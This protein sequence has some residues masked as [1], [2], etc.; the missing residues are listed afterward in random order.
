MKVS[1]DEVL[2]HRG[3]IESRAR[4]LSSDEHEAEDLTQ[5]TLLYALERPPKSSFALR[6]WLRLVV[7]HLAINS[8]VSRRRQL[9]REHRVAR[10]SDL[11]EVSHAPSMEQS[12]EVIRCV[13][14]LHEPYRTVITQHYLEGHNTSQIAS[15]LGIPVGT[16]KSR[17]RKGRELLL[18][19]YSRPSSPRTQRRFGVG[20]LLGLWPTEG[21]R[22]SIWGWS[23]RGLLVVSASLAVLLSI[24]DGWAS[25]TPVSGVAA[26]EASRASDSRANQVITREVGVFGSATEHRRPASVDG[27]GVRGTQVAAEKALGASFLV[28]GKHG[29]AIAFVDIQFVPEDANSTSARQGAGAIFSSSLDGWGSLDAALGPGLL[30]SA[31]PEWITVREGVVDP[32]N[33]HE[34]PVVMVAPAK[35]I[36]GRVVDPQGNPISKAA[37]SARWGKNIHVRVSNAASKN[38]HGKAVES[39]EEGR[40]RLPAADLDELIVRARHPDFEELQIQLAEFTGEFVMRPPSGEGMRLHGVVLD[41]KGALVPAAVVSVRGAHTKTDEEGRYELFLPA[42]RLHEPRTPKAMPSNHGPL[43][44][45]AM[46]PEFGIG[47]QALTAS[48]EHECVLHLDQAVEALRGVVVDEDG[49]P[50]RGAQV[51]IT[52]PTPSFQPRVQRVENWLTQMHPSGRVH[53]NQDG[54]FELYVL[55]GEEYSLRVLDASGVRRG[56]LEVS[57]ETRE[58]E[59]V[60][61]A[62]GTP[63]T[64]DGRVLDRQGLGVVGAEV[65]LIDVAWKTRTREFR[66]EATAI[67]TAR[68]DATGHFLLEEVPPLPM[69]LR[70]VQDGLV[71]EERVFHPKNDSGVQIQVIRGCRVSLQGLPADTSFAQFFS[72]RSDEPLRVGSPLRVSTLTQ[73]DRSLVR[74]NQH[75]SRSMT[76]PSD[77]SRLVA[78]RLEGYE[79]VE[80]ET[81]DLTYGPAEEHGRRPLLLAR[82]TS[83]D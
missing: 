49:V 3:F 2:K 33:P 27:G 56:A 23:W 73:P 20:A 26:L 43:Q 10:E 71:L 40:F 75:L 9:E 81:F 41:A 42:A 17:L 47:V 14:A 5:R 65:H 55:R 35:E 80:I 74:W 12:S 78:Y 62:V 4:A 22:P 48:S 54:V 29:E 60:L 79:I 1:I 51:W 76:L 16:V 67:A 68:T 15:R 70:V 66:R 44:A 21:S 18:S 34:V 11:G 46:H 82:N 69:T 36:S 64:A 77:A 30:R 52:N 31:D 24:S 7:R 63:V 13:E 32:W 57:A 45:L 58:V 8:R 50:Q 72:E 6:T 39:D 37:V 25:S 53:T 83:G 61:R 19:T 38:A 28:Q 59:L